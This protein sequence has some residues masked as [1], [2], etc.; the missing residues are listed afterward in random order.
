MRQ[1]I[2]THVPGERPD[3]A[4]VVEAIGPLVAPPKAASD[5]AGRRAGRRRG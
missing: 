4:K 2:D 5:D 3:M 1:A